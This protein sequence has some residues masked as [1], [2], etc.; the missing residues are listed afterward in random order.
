[1]SDMN[2]YLKFIFEMMAA[3]RETVPASEFK[4]EF[5]DVKA[6]ILMSGQWYLARATYDLKRGELEEFVE[7]TGGD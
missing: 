5:S 4:V 3:L 6:V 2:R 7:I 1:M